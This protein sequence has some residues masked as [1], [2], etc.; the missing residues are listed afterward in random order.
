[1]TEREF[2]RRIDERELLW[3]ARD[4]CYERSSVLVNS[5]EW[6]GLSAMC[7]MPPECLDDKLIERIIRTLPPET[8]KGT[9]TYMDEFLAAFPAAEREDDGTPVACRN[10]IYGEGCGR[11]QLDGIDTA[12]EDADVGA[13]CAACWREAVQ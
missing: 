13:V 9:T 7:K 6:C 1:M 10:H 12:A 11:C 4:Y 8:E 5:C 3:R 2:L